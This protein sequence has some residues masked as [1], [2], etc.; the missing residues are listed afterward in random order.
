M[1]FEAVEFHARR[2]PLATA[3]IDADSLEYTYLE[4]YRDLCAL[5]EKLRLD[6]PGLVSM[7]P[8]AISHRD[9]RLHLLMILALETLGIT[10]L[11]FVQP[12]DP[13]FEKTLGLCGMVLA[14]EPVEAVDRPFFQLAPQW[15]EDAL[16]GNAPAPSIA[17]WQP[18]AVTIILTTSGS[19]GD[20]KAIPLHR[21]AFEMR[22]RDWICRRGLTQGSAF[23]LAL[24][25][26]M[27][28]IGVSAR[29]T[30]RCGGTIVFWNRER[31]LEALRRATHATLMPGSLHFLLS[32]I[33]DSYNRPGTLQLTSIGAPLAK[34]LRQRIAEKLDAQIENR[35]GS[36]E[37][38]GAMRIGADGIGDVNPGVEL[39]VVDDSM[40][41][42]AEG[43]PG[44]I[45]GR[46]IS[47]ARRYVDRRQTELS[48]KD[49]WYLTGDYGVARGY[50]RIE[51]LGRSD[52]MLNLGGIKIAPE[53]VE[54]SLG[55]Q[56]IARDLA[57]CTLEDQS[58]VAILHIA[59]CGLLFDAATIKAKVQQS[60][61]SNFGEVR[62][63]VVETIPRAVNGKL[64][65]SELK[66]LLRRRIDRGAR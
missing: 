41:T 39:E 28:S 18:D 14:E 51:L 45:R 55:L 16:A 29:A 5:I 63:V 8:V 13:G 1:S 64:R 50:R 65:R 59:L 20:A 17:W 56:M 10:S 31:P 25:P 54:A 15:F 7:Q 6:L 21:R 4:L 62:L 57:V 32:Q 11:P 61:G 23:L 12:I 26:S 36:N 46:S 37:L 48:F 40:Q 43:Q 3:L 34:E 60:L 24:P 2:T 52:D 66:E 42:V 49:G 53:R 19:S 58:G 33:P 35:Y 47:M 30:L 9:K 44:M 22:E 38:G 27:F